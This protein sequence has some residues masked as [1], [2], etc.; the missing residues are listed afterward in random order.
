MDKI[1]QRLLEW[2]NS[3]P[4]SRKVIKDHGPAKYSAVIIGHNLEPD[5]KEIE[6]QIQHLIGRAYQVEVNYNGNGSTNIMV[7]RK[8]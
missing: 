1:S 5:K 3:Q 2:L 4:Y 7:I 6:S 8:S